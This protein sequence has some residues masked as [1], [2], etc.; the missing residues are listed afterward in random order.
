[1]KLHKPRRLALFLMCIFP[2]VINAAEKGEGEKKA[3]DPVK[4]MKKL[5]ADKSGSLSKEEVAGNA[6]L[7]KRFQKIDSNKDGE[8]SLAEFSAAMSMPKKPKKEK[9]EEEKE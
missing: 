5:D 4:M 9:E 1:M 2:I 6:V 8:L 3:P 7:T